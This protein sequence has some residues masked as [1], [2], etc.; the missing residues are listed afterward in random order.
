MNFSRVSHGREKNRLCFLGSLRIFQNGVLRWRKF[1]SLC[2]KTMKFG[3]SFR[4]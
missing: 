1:S 2:R 3:L 4:I